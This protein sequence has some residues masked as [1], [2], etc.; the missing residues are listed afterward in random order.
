MSV[1]VSITVTDTATPFVW[2]KIKTFSLANL[3]KLVGPALNRQLRQHFVANRGNK[4]GWPTTN[5]WERAARATSW[6]KSGAGVVV[7]V[8][9]IGVRQRVFGGTVKAVNASALTIPISPV[10][11]GHVASDFPGL[12]FLK[13]KKGAYLVQAGQQISEKGNLTKRTKAGGNASR[14][15][16]AQLNFLFKLAPSVMQAADPTVLPEDEQIVNTALKAIEEAS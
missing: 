11:Y 14:R 12:F 15:L 8:N 3:Q 7:S 4:K 2:E 5:F 1:G 6:D 9:Q 13:T 10:S 16:K